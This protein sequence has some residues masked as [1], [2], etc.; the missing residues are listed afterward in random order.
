MVCGFAH[1]ASIVW[2]SLKKEIYQLQNA[3]KRELHHMNTC[4]LHQKYYQ[5]NYNKVKK[6]IMNGIFTVN[7]G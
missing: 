5:L 6:V 2:W 4:D 3:K 7:L 1:G